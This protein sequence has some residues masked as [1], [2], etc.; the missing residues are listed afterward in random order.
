MNVWMTRALRTAVFTGGLLAVGTGIASADDSTTDVTVPVTVT[1]NALAV[2]GTAPGNDTPAEI[3]PPALSGSVA[4][5]LGA[6]TASVPVTLAG[7]AADVA[8]LDAAQPP[9]PT[10][11]ADPGGSPV[12][13]TPVGGPEADADVPVTVTGNAIGVLGDATAGGDAG[14]AARGGS[15]ASRVDAEVPVTAC[16]NGVGVLGDASG[17][18]TTAAGTGGPGTPPLSGR[19]GTAPGTGFPQVGAPAWSAMPAVADGSPIGN[20]AV[21]SDGRLAYTGSTVVLPL[22][23]GLLALALGLG[24]TVA[25]RRRATVLR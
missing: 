17:A 14:T 4:V 2:L 20:G 19:P 24:L 10:A 21:A 25:S 11:P 5:D 12:G 16:G 1:D 7:N 8:G 9:A 18:C 13:G 3:T 23:A 15:D 22:V 6:A